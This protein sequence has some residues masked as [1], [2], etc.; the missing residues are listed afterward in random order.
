MDLIEANPTLVMGFYNVHEAIRD[1]EKRLPKEQEDL[2]DLTTPALLEGDLLS[3]ITRLAQDY[4][5]AMRLMDIHST[6][7]L[8]RL[9]E[10]V[11]LVDLAA[12][13]QTYYD[14]VSAPVHSATLALLRVKFL[15]YLTEEGFRALQTR[16]HGEAP[17]TTLLAH[18][19]SLCAVV[20]RTGTQTQKVQ[21][22]LCQV[23]QLALQGRF[24]AAR[25][26]MLMAHLQEQMVSA[27]MD[28]LVL[29]NRAMAQLGVAAFR[30]GSMVYA[31]NCLDDLVNASSRAGVLRV[32]IGQGSDSTHELRAGEEDM[33]V[34]E[35]RRK[36]PAHMVCDE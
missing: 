27:D 8:Q 4:C 17:T 5:T 19:Q 14:R 30:A 2:A 18:L 36:L 25:D 22:A 35:E 32:L 3:Y 16:V 20:Y 10:E 6:L 33:R 12:R 29:F 28:T 23:Y 9:Q 13:V 15:Y 7:Y 11:Q 34:N 31:H 1:Y 24:M 26:L 21:A